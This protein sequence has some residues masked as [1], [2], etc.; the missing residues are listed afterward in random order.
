MHGA[1]GRRRG[2]DCIHVSGI[3]HPSQLL[4]RGDRRV[5]LDQTREHPGGNECVRYGV[6]TFRTLGVMAPHIV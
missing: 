2:F 4:A 6:E 3:V 5:V 1:V